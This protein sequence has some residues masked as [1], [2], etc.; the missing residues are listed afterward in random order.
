MTVAEIQGL[1]GD[2]FKVCFSDGTE[3]KTGLELITDFSLYKGRE[4]SGEEYGKLMDASRLSDCKNRALR[5]IGRRPMSCRELYDKLAEKGESPANAE[6]SVNWLLKL[7]YLD[8]EQ[9]AGM[10][11]RHYA[12]KGYGRKKIQ[13]ELYNRGIPKDLWDE[14]F[15]EMPDTAETVYKLLRRRLN[16]P[17]PD[18][19]EIKKATDSLYRRG[20]SWDEI[21]A[22]LNRFESESED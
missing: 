19:N 2:R 10:L 18:R 8:D 5:L 9:Y 17:E 20:F 16:S 15:S 12:A 14:A 13:N 4:L 6:A 1:R 22:A 21:K 3:L 7:H 11:V